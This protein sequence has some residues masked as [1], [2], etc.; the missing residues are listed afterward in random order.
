MFLV[1]IADLARA[2]SNGPLEE[3]SHRRPETPKISPDRLRK[4]RA[5]TPA[6]ARPNAVVAHAVFGLMATA[7]AVRP[8]GQPP[9]ADVSSAPAGFLRGRSVLRVRVL[10]A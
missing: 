7:M 10:R 9:R 5:F 2:V 3:G 8:L 4:T 1:R 6:A